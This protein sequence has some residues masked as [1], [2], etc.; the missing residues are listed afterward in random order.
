MSFK[1]LEDIA[2]ITSAISAHVDIEILDNFRIPSTENWFLD[3]EVIFFKTVM[4]R[5][6]EQKGLKPF[7]RK[8]K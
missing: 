3:D 7:F 5:D 4:H 2:I 6:T 8:G 1:G